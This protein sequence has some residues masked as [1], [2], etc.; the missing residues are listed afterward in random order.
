MMLWSWIWCSPFEFMCPSPDTFGPALACAKS[1]SPSEPCSAAQ[2]FES[3]LA[4]NPHGEERLKAESMKETYN[5]QCVRAFQNAKSCSERNRQIDP[6]VAQQCYDEFLKDRQAPR[7]NRAEAERSA[8]G[9]GL[10]CDT[11][12]RDDADRQAAAQAEV[13]IAEHRHPPCNSSENCL[14]SY[15]A[16]SPSG[17]QRGRL[18]R[19]ARETLEKCEGEAI[20][21]ER[22]KAD[23]TAGR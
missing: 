18:S 3:F 17:A 12:K 2:C 23:S 20:S 16:S 15:T 19:L 6:C 8:G 1:T 7:E 21:I 5:L 14:A 11:R 13:C 4:T 22:T 9:F 10:Q